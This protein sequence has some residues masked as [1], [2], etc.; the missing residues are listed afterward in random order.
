MTTQDARWSADPMITAHTNRGVS[1]ACV[2]PLTVR[3]LPKMG[4]DCLVDLLDYRASFP[5]KKTRAAVCLRGFRLR[6]S[7]IREPLS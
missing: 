2:Q 1:A 6:F 4:A 5:V 7:P 3:D